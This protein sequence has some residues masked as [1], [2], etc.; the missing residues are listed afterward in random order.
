MYHIV[1]NKFERK[2]VNRMGAIWWLLIVI[3]GCWLLVVIPNYRFIKSCSIEEEKLLSEADLNKMILRSVIDAAIFI[4]I[5]I[6]GWLLYYHCLPYSINKYTH[7]IMKFSENDDGVYYI[8]DGKYTSVLEKND[9]GNYEIQ[10]VPSDKVDYNFSD[11][12]EPS[13]TVHKKE[14]KLTT[15]DRILTFGN[16]EDDGEIEKI[17]LTIPKE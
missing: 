5:F 1:R 16:P 2:E 13:I 10:S 6:F 15:L 9:N 11:N 8:S 12:E 17:V 7:S 4:L 3:C 14:Y